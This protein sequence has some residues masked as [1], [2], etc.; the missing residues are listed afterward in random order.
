M[1]A[2]IIAV[3]SPYYATTDKTGAF[4]IRDVPAGRYTYHAWRSGADDAQR[5]RHGRRGAAA[6]GR[7]AMR[8]AAHSHAR[9]GGRARRARRGSSAGDRRHRGSGR[10]GGTFHRRR[11]RRR[12]AGPHLRRRCRA[13][14]A[15]SPRP[16]GPTTWG[17]HSDA[18]GA[19]YPYNHRVR[20]MELFA[21]EDGDAA[22]RSLW[23][24]R[25]GRYRTPFG[26]SN[27]SDHAYTGFLR[28]PLIRYGGYWALSNNF[29][30]TG[31]SVVAGTPRLFA[32][33]SLG[34]PQ[35][36]DDL[37][38]APRVRPRRPRAGD[39]G[40]RDRRHQLHPHPALRRAGRG[41]TAATEFTGRRRPLDDAAACSCAANGSTA[42][43]S[44]APAPS[45]AMPT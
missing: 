27:R 20:P 32:E 7:V 5:H 8:S 40:R 29:L 45:A 2:Y 39:A 37:H 15:S 43:R 35:D 12:H 17:E 18:F 41:P 23:G 21:R 1:A 10:H 36:E 13:T 16:R 42:V 22:A 38:R 9:H 6:G 14:G 26:L 19:A 3:D 30:E 33:V 11:A 44:T 24:T 4:A 28:A 25:V 34:I 31:A